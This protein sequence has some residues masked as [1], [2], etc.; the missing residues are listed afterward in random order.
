MAR[1]NSVMPMIRVGEIASPQ[2]EENESEPEGAL[3]WSD[4]ASEETDSRQGGDNAQE[5]ESTAGGRHVVIA[6]SFLNPE[7]SQAM[8]EELKSKGYQPYITKVTIGDK[9]YRRVNVA[10]FSSRQQADKLAEELADAG[11]E[12]RVGVR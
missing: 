12:V 10:A 4:H 5:T 2:G 9:T 11:Y 8:L 1:S 7:K 3:S 6:G